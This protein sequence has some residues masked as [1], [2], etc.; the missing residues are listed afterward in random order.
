VC[1]RWVFGYHNPRLDGISVA[2]DGREI[3]DQIGN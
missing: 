1:R 3:V 2:G